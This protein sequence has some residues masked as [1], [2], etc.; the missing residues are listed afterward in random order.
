[1]G[2]TRRDGTSAGEGQPSEAQR[3]YLERGL[4][5]PRAA[6]LTFRQRLPHL[7]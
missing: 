7:V 6:D 3:R 5:Q 2:E 1:M 4:S